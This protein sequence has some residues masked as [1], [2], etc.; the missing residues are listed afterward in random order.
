[1][2]S[3]KVEPGKT[4]ISWIGTGVMGR[5]MPA[6][7]DQG[8]SATVSNRTRQGPAAHRAGRPEPIRRKQSRSSRMW[9]SPS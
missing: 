5:W 8:Y 2:A 3:I 6:P 9:F 1:M 7:H 4:R